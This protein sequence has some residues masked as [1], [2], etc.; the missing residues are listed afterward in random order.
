MGRTPGVRE[1]AGRFVPA[2]GG[3]R[4]RGE[5]APFSFGMLCRA[6]WRKVRGKG[7][8]RADRTQKEEGRAS[9]EGAFQADM[10]GTRAA[11]DRTGQMGRPCWSERRSGGSRAGRAGLGGLGFPPFG[12]ERIAERRFRPRATAPPRRSSRGHA[13][14]RHSPVAAVLL[15]ERSH[16]LPPNFRSDSVSKSFFAQRTFCGAGWHRDHGTRRACSGGSRLRNTHIQPIGPETARR[17]PHGAWP[18]TTAN[19]LGSS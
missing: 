7:G 6:K 10:H 8:Q 19:F 17:G 9:G 5:K 15:R 13:S 14:R 12:G 1:G 2:T 3:G 18:S 16:R 11:A 4:G